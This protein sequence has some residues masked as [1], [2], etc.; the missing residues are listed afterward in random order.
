M[1]K[2]NDKKINKEKKRFSPDQYQKNIK[3]CIL[4]YIIAS[5]LGCFVG[6]WL[7]AVLLVLIG[8]LLYKVILRAPEVKGLDLAAD[9]PKESYVALNLLSNEFMKYGK[10]DQVTSMVDQILLAGGV[11]IDKKE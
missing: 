4:S 11:Q 2:N 7:F 10:D 8:F 3:I 9:L 1:K 5:L 6:H